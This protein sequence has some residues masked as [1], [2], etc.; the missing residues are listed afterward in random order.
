VN[1]VLDLDQVLGIILNSATELLEGSSGSVMLFEN[2][3]EMRV[4]CE[5]GNAAARGATV[6]IGDG[7]AGQVA[8]LREPM[9]ITGTIDRDPRAV[10]VTTAMCVPLVNRDEVLGVLNVNGTNERRFTEYD[11]RALTL[12]AEHA[13][14]AIANARL[15]EAELEHVAEL[16][17][18]DRMKSEFV[19]T[20]SHELRTPLTS[21]L[22]CT[23]TM[24]RRQLAPEV[25]DEFLQMIERQGTRLLHL[26][27]DILDVQRTT[28][29]VEP[30]P[31]GPVALDIVLDEVVR[32]QA[33]TGR[34]VALRAGAG[35]VVLADRPS[36]ERVFTNLVDNAFSHGGGEVEIEMEE[37]THDGAEA[38]LVCVL[39]RGPGVPPEDAERI[40]DRFKRGPEAFSP[41]MGLGL[42]MVR[43]LVEAQGGRVWVTPRPGGGAAFRVLLP[44][45]HA[46]E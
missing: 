37:T 14:I 13:S 9:L 35:V 34:Q 39:D 17:E 16:V 43:S 32:M 36:L 22:G 19:A 1:S 18:L 20:V 41:G 21:I 8:L 5:L 27:E 42:Y 28:A 38:T 29:A 15:Y 6:R 23:R 24:Q 31:C 30:P 2:V 10:P 25:T 44:C 12:F 4:V 26:I 46:E 3:E 11:L 33:A 40:F 7:I 45:A